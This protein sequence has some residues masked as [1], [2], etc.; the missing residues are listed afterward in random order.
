MKRKS[1]RKSDSSRCVDPKKPWHQQPGQTRNFLDS[2]CSVAQQVV[3]ATSN[4]NI[5]SVVDLYFGHSAPPTKPFLSLLHLESR[6]LTKTSNLAIGSYAIE[7]IVVRFLPVCCAALFL[8]AATDDSWGQ[9][10]QR[11][12]RVSIGDIIEY[13][14]FHD[15]MTFGLVVELKPFLR[16]ETHDGR[17]EFEKKVVPQRKRPRQSEHGNRS[18]GSSKS[19]PLWLALKTDKQG[20]KKQ[21]GKSSQSL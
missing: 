1:L 4:S 21:T 6:M 8:F 16:V 2:F 5:L 12:V 3:I 13:E 19:K 15:G 9:R 10:R 20:S 14:D 17:R 11:S 18:M 7:F